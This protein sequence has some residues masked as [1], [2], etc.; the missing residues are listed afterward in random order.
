[1][2]C[3]LLL[4][5]RAAS[6]LD[7]ACTPAA[8]QQ[9]LKALH[10]HAEKNLKALR[11]IMETLPQQTRLAFIGDGPEAAELKRHYADMPN[12]KFMVCSI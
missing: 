2:S 11:T 9:S 4:L 6:Y 5:G 7:A 3:K 8:R 10:V 1:M 12:V